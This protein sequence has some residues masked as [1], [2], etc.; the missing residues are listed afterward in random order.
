MIEADSESIH[1]L[2]NTHYNRKKCITKT[3]LK[4]REL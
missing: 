4:Q 1:Y 3:Q 2:T